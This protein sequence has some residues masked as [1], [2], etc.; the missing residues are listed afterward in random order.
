VWGDYAYKIGISET[1]DL[2]MGLKAGFTSYTN[3]LQEHILLPGVN[4]PMFQG[5]LQNKFVPNFG[6]G[7]FL[8]NPKYYIGFSV[9]KLLHQEIVGDN[10]NNFSLQSD[11]RHYFLEGGYVFDLSENVKFK[12]TFLTKATTGAPIQLDLSANFLLRDQFWVGAMYRTRDAVGLIAQWII[13]ND[14]RI[15]YAYDYTLTKLQNYHHGTHE[16]MV[17]YEL[18]SL[19]EMIV[20]PRYF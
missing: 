11:I 15:G 13:K 3:N 18:R 20:S 17:S 8:Q 16:I 1:T 7:L 12:P 10:S 4:D 6:V 19:K 14:L 9:P 2:R 5:D